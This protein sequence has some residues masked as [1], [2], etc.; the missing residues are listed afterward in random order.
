MIDFRRGS[1]T[2]EV[3]HDSANRLLRGRR[4]S[5]D[6]PPPPEIL[7]DLAGTPAEERVDAIKAAIRSNPEQFTLLDGPPA[8]RVSPLVVLTL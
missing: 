4:H 6:A 5:A 1:L 2:H 7:A 3:T 8:H